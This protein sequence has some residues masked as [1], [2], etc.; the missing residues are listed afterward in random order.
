MTHTDASRFSCGG[1]LKSYFNLQRTATGKWRALRA[2]ELAS[3][4]IRPLT[5]YP[6]S[7]DF[8]LF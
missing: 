8:F 2:G 4:G 3:S 7:H 1:H 6:T 5:Y